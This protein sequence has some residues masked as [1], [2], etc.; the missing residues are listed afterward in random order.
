MSWFRDHVTPPIGLDLDGRCFRAVQQIDD[1]NSP[2]KHAMTPSPREDPSAPLTDAEADQLCTVLE[3]GGFVGNRLV[4]AAPASAE[5]SSVLELPPRGSGA[6]LADIARSEMA[7]LQGCDPSEIE[8]SAWLLPQPARAGDATF[9]MATACSHQQVAPLV[10]AL[11]HRGWDVAALDCRTWA[12]ARACLPHMVGVIGMTAVVELGW[13]ETRLVICKDGTVVYE[14]SIP[15]GGVR[16]LATALGGKFDLRGPDISE[17][18][19][20]L[21]VEETPE[22]ESGPTAGVRTQVI[23][24][25]QRLAEELHAPFCYVENLYPDAAIRRM[26]LVGPG[27]AIGGLAGYIAELVDVD[28]EVVSVPITGTT[29]AG[30]DPGAAVAAGLALYGYGDD[31]PVDLLPSEHVRAKLRRRRARRWVTV[32]G[33]YVA[34]LVIVYLGCWVFGGDATRCDPKD[35]DQA[36][37]RISLCDEQIAGARAQLDALGTLQE[38][39]QLV[40][41]QPDWSILLSLISRDLGPEVVLKGLRFDGTSLEA[42]MKDEDDLATEDTPSPEASAFLFELAGLGRSQMAVSQFVLRLEQGGIFDKVKL[43]KTNREEYLSG[44][45][46]AFQLAC[47]LGSR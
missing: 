16:G 5:T 27:A 6:P 23:A 7:R 3:Q 24:Y 43:V 37:R 22:G 32:G 18:M 2:Y 45:A 44:R 17:V 10:S 14:R 39:Q 4:V 12:L 9:M 25:V 42:P 29:D 41:C 19:A 28:A 47:T 31:S 21:S 35:I 8:F 33:A 38:A 11:E 26:L 20:Q 30:T 13:R 34:L 40:E 15:D 1:G 46:V 36:D